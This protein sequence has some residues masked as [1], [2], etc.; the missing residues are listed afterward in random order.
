MGLSESL[1][2][3]GEAIPMPHITLSVSRTG[4]PVN[5]RNL[6]FAPMTP[7]T[8]ER[9]FGGLDMDDNLCM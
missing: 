7:F 5:S 3:L 1:K 2:A 9:I 4:K 8:I 6:H